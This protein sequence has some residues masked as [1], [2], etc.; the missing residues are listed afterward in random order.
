[1]NA[2]INIGVYISHRFLNFYIM[3][4]M[5]KHVLKKTQVFKR[6]EYSESFDDIC[7][8]CQ[9]LCWLKKLFL[10]KVVEK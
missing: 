2:S 5:D 7:P 4:C 10:R 1:M 6:D 3:K 8:V 9:S